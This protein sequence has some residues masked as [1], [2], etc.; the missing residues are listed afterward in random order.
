[1]LLSIQNLEAGYGQVTVLKKISLHV[2]AGE[3]VAIIGANGAGKTTS[4]MAISGIV[5]RQSG[6]ITFCDEEI[7]AL[8][9]HEIVEKGISHVPE[10]RRI[11]PRLSVL[12][13]L[14][15]GAYLQKNAK[16]Q[17]SDLEMVFSLFPLLKERNTQRGGT[18]SGGEQQ[19][20]AIAR[21]LMSRPKLLI[22]DEP[23]LG[24][25]P[26]MVEK[27]FEM[28]QVI[29]KQGL[30]ILLVEQNAHAALMLANRAY[31]METGKIT[32]E[33]QAQNLLENKEVQA[34]YLGA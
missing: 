24:L 23:S 4:L 14:Q 19:M 3:I 5:S 31:V 17:D 32:L 13:N 26:L 25:S 7:I 10:G 18:L 6:Q 29:N 2:T 34:A 12:E 21:A 33:D 9:A 28:I 11:F 8:S 15:M 1:M 22:L 20:L 30:T 27:I 16:D